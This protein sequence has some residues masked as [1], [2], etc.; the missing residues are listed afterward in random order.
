MRRLAPQLLTLAATALLLG[1]CGVQN[2]GCGASP[3][4]PL[5]QHDLSFNGEHDLTN[6]C[7][8]RCGDGPLEPRPLDADGGCDYA[9]VECTDEQGHPATLAC[10]G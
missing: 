3:D 9:D 7:A 5:A 2:C 8:C 1:G 10:G 4:D 6:E